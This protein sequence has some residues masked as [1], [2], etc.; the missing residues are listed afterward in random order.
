[1]AQ[2]TMT[3]A[4]KLANVSRRTIQRYAKSGKLSVTKDRHGNPLVDTSE[5]LRVFEELVTPK[6]EKKSQPV[7]TLET[8]QAQIELLT[9]KVDTQSQEIISLSHRLSLDGASP[10]ASAR[11]P[12]K[13]VRLAEAKAH[14]LAVR[15][16]QAK[17][18]TP[19]DTPIDILR[20]IMKERREELAAAEEA[21]LVLE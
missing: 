2:H 8:L 7:V 4:A 18:K 13:K 5:L 9:Q 3:E 21:V 11:K 10:R 17:T 15:A 1:M 12:P 19:M 16:R 6:E 14:L 20:E